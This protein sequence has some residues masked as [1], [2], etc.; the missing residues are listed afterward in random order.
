MAERFPENGA[1]ELASPAGS[2]IALRVLAYVAVVVAFAQIMFGAIVRITGSGMGCGDHWPTCQG[3]LIPP[4]ERPDLIIEVTHR[5]L[6]ATVTVVILALL[7]TAFMQRANRGVGGPHGILR[8]ALLAMSL[9]LVAAIF[10]AIT[11]KLSLNP[12][13]IVTHLS[14]AMTLLAVL[15]ITVLRAGG[16]GWDGTGAASGRT[17]RSSRVAVILAFL[18]LVFGALTANV[19]GANI[20]CQGF[21]TCRSVLV[22]GAPLYI[23]VTHRVLAFLLLFHMIGVVIG[24]RKRRE[25]LLLRR[26]AW[27]A[28]GAI[29]LQIIIAA[30]MVEMHLPPGWRSLHQAIGT[31]VW[32]AIFTMAA[33]ARYS[34]PDHRTAAVA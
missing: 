31:L 34:L 10:G 20:S 6:A 15:S 26:A 28:M 13:V 23:Q 1:G 12:Y 3:F 22:T 5:Y 8:S 29:F 4:L 11:V 16:W 21:P 7:L 14:I 17:Y 24:V 27:F 25:S 9:V 30:G 18:I 19:A 33:I 32:L 2:N